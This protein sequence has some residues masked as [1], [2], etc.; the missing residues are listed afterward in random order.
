MYISFKICVRF[1]CFVYVLVVAVTDENNLL[2]FHF[3][4]VYIRIYLRFIYV[5][6]YMYILFKICVPF[7]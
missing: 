4:D 2:Y 6:E 3:V 1:K 5:L 7:K